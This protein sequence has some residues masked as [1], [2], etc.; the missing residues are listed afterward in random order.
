MQIK[1]VLEQYGLKEMHAAIYLSCLEL[2]S[3][4]IQ[5]ISQKSGFARSTCEAVLESL[6]EKGFVTAFRKKNVRYFSPEDPKK[7]VNLAKE[8]VTL[9]ESALPQFGALYYKGDTSPLS[10]L[11]EG[12]DGVRLVLQEILEE[13][14]EIMSFGSIDDI[15][16]R[17]GDYFP[18]FTKERIK[19]SIPLKVILQDSPLAEERKKLGAQEL[20]EVRI[21]KE[22]NGLSSVTFIWNNKIAMCSF[23][24]KIIA[25][26]VQ[27]E[28]LANIQK[29]MFTLI[30][31]TLK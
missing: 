14:R 28:E 21:M 11:Y 16:E 5:K 31:N 10:R 9:L 6:H 2:G 1:K 25:L 22:G 4:S 19:R 30:W 13:A 12:E 15:Y 8:K 24:E 23:K 18:K 17:L 3:A 29:T 7:L 26:V 20:R 27:S